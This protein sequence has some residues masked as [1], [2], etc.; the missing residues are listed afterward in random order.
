MVLLKLSLLL[1]TNLLPLLRGCMGYWARLGYLGILV[2]LVSGCAQQLPNLQRL[3]P[4]PPGPICRVAVLPFESDSDYPLASLIA[5]MVFSAQ[6]TATENFIVAQA[7]DVHKIYQQ[8][9]ILPGYPLTQE[10]YRIL[11]SRLN[12]QLLITGKVIKMQ[13]NPAAKGGV[14]PVLTLQIDILDG[15]TAKTLWSTYHHRQ[16]LDYQKAMHFGTIHSVTDLSQQVAVEIINL[17]FKQGLTP[18]DVSP[19]Y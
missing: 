15:S 4:L 10:Q 2:L 17:W 18:C 19:L 5:S 3:S 1:Q 7:G 8:L 6:L 16:G 14:N 9:R 13:E 12:V 11:G